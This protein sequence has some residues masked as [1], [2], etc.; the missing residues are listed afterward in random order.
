M[1]R[2]LFRRSG[3]T[4]LVLITLALLA[5]EHIPTEPEVVSKE[6]LSQ[7]PFERL[8]GKILFRRTLH[9]RPGEYY[10]MLLEAAS[11]QLKVVAYFGSF[12][13]ANFALSHDANR[14]VFSYFIYASTFWGYNWQLYV[15]DLATTSWRRL[16][17]SEY[18]DSFPAWSP[19]DSHIAFWTNRDL[20]SSIWLADL[21][22]DSASHVVNVSDSIHTR[23]AWLGDGNAFVY[24]TVDTA[25]HAGLYRFDLRNRAS[26]LLYSL[27][28][29]VSQAIIKHPALSPDETRV[30]FVRAQVSG[31]D[32]I[33]VFELATAVASRLTTGVSDWHPAWSADGTQILFGRGDHLVIMRSDG[34]ELAQ[35]TFG[36]HTN[37]YPSWVP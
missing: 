13:P 12:V 3:A 23:V 17:P 37:E 35:V 7:V 33:W 30:A 27:E 19:D 20:R 6:E 21:A 22:T 18:D 32:E 15:M 28:V 4:A 9:D 26:T 8:S 24:V 2:G 36:K 25:H 14:A 10:L 16:C 29:P 34:S 11:R 1:T 31:I 5:C